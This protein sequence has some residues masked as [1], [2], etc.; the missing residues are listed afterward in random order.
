M[1]PIGTFFA[2]FVAAGTL[3]SLA[4]PGEAMPLNGLPAASG[5]NPTDTIAICQ[6]AAGCGTT[7]PLHHAQMGAVLGGA[8]AAAITGVIT[9]GNGANHVQTPSPA[10]A[11][12]SR[13]R[14]RRAA[15]CRQAPY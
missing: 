13:F 6:K 2:T 15:F 10:R 1:K 9:L 5:V 7:D 12:R 4:P 11:T 14:N 8:A 3:L